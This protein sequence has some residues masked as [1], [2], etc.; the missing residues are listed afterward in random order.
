MNRKLVII[1][2]FPI[3]SEKTVRMYFGGSLS[4]LVGVIPG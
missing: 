1:E 2:T 4:S 3:G